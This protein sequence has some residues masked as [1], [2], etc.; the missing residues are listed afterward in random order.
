MCQLSNTAIK[1][2]VYVNA[3]FKDLGYSLKSSE[4]YPIFFLW[5]TIKDHMIETDLSE[6]GGG[7]QI[8]N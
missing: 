2:I 8:L 7:L 6:E 3:L 4:S 5:I 1:A